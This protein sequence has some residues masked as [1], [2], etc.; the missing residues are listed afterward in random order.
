MKKKFDFIYPGNQGCSDSQNGS[1]N[2]EKK[3]M[4]ILNPFCG[5]H[6]CL[7]SP[8]KMSR[9]TEKIQQQICPALPLSSFSVFLFLSKT[10]RF[11]DKENWDFALSFLALLSS[12]LPGHSFIQTEAFVC[13]IWGWT[14]GKYYYSLMFCIDTSQASLCTALAGFHVKLFPL[15]RGLTGSF[16]STVIRVLWLCR[17]GLWT[18]LSREKHRLAVTACLT[19]TGLHSWNPDALSGEGECWDFQ[20]PSQSE[21]R[22][23]QF[24]LGPVHGQVAAQSSEINQVWRKATPPGTGWEE[25]TG[26]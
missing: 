5:T 19:R 12:C 24:D 1:L 17:A 18:V 2:E 4:Y 15:S 14:E 20:W 23:Q 6:M 3:R 9:K 25:I 21:E 8:Y 7:L 16:F 26:G 13:S 10:V 11:P 22:K